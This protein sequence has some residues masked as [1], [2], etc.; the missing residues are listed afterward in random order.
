MIETDFEITPIQESLNLLMS[1]NNIT[2]EELIQPPKHAINT[3]DNSIDNSMLNPYTAVFEL[4]R[5]TI[6]Y[7]TDIYTDTTINSY[8]DVPFLIDSGKFKDVVYK[9]TKLKVEN[10]KFTYEVIVDDL[11][12]ARIKLDIVE[13]KYIVENIIKNILTKELTFDTFR[14]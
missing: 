8:V 10:N 4:P 12:E 3:I 2:Y 1:I 11:F 6:T 5:F 13:F 9:Y 7:N 14:K